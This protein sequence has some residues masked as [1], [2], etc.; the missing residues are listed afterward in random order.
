MSTILF[1]LLLIVAISTYVSVGFVLGATLCKR[2]N[3]SWKW[4]NSNLGEFIMSL[5][6]LGIVLFSIFWPLQLGI[7]ILLAIPEYVRS[8]RFRFKMR[9][10]KSEKPNILYSDIDISSLYANSVYKPDTKQLN[11]KH[12]YKRDRTS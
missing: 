2:S 7:G 5:D 4:L 8:V 6:W 9:K 12:S 10:A 3:A 1:I 11:D